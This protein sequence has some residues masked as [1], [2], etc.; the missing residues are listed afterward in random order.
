MNEEQFK[1]FF[2]SSFLSI[3]FLP[4]IEQLERGKGNKRIKCGYEM[5]QM[6]SGLGIEPMT[7]AVRL[8]PLYMRHLPTI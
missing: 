1:H 2:L 8:Y 4:S 6:I 5:D 3:I 7:S